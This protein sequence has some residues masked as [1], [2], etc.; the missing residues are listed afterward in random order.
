MKDIRAFMKVC[1]LKFGWI[2]KNTFGLYTHETKKVKINIV[3]AI[4]DIFI[5][6]AMH[7]K[8]PNATEKLVSAK[9]ARKMNR[10]SI[11]EHKE[12][13]RFI[14]YKFQEELKLYIKERI[15]NEEKR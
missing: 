14:Y 6:E 13:G 7:E 10:L 2:D 5:H 8:Y 15:K 11:K 3:L 9:T 1:S 12:I 4:V